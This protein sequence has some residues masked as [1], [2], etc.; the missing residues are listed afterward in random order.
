LNELNEIKDRDLQPADLEQVKK[1][2][3]NTRNAAMKIGQSMNNQSNS[4]SSS[5]SSGEESKDSK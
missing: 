1:A 2:I 4:S 5:S 3:E